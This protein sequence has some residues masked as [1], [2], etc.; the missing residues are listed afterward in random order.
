MDFNQSSKYRYKLFQCFI[1]TTIALF[2][3]EK[4]S[5]AQS[6][7]PVWQP[8]YT[9]NS[10]PQ[11]QPQQAPNDPELNRN[12]TAEELEQTIRALELIEVLGFT[13]LNVNEVSSI[14]QELQQLSTEQSPPYK[15]SPQQ[16]Q[17]LINLFATLS[18]SELTA[19][20]QILITQNSQASIA[21]TPEEIQNL[22]EVLSS[23]PTENLSNL[24]QEQ[25]AVIQDFFSKIPAN[26]TV[27]LSPEQ[28]EALGSAIEFV[29][30]TPEA[31]STATGELP[32]F[33]RSEQVTLT[34]LEL[35]QTI[36]GLQAIQQ[37]NLRPNQE[38]EITQLLN[39]LENQQETQ[40]DVT[41]SAAQ[42]Q[43]L[44]NLIG[45]LTPN[46]TA[47]IEILLLSDR[48]PETLDLTQQEIDDLLTFFQELPTE[49]FTA[50]QRQ[51][52]TELINFL[53][54]IREQEATEIRLS[55]AQTQAFLQGIQILL[56][57]QGAI[58]SATVP[59]EQLQN[60]ITYIET[61]QKEISLSSSQAQNIAELRQK[62]ANLEPNANNQ[63]VI[64]PEQNQQLRTFINS[65]NRRQ[66]Q[67][68]QR[69]LIVQAGGSVSSPSISVLNPIG[70]GNSWGNIGV[71]LSY[72]ER[73]RFGD[74]EDGSLSFSMG[75]GDPQRSVG[76]DTTVTILSL[77]DDNQSAAFSTGSMSF[78]LSRN[79]SNNTAV[80][81]G[82]EN[83]IRWPEGSGDSGTSTYL[84]GSKLFQLR[85][86]P[87]SPFGIAYLTAG[88]GNGRFRPPEDFDFEDDGF[89]FNPF[90][91]LAV[92]VL[93]RVNAMTE[94]TGQDISVGLSIVPFREIPLVITLAGIDL[95]GN[96]EEAFGREGKA[97]FTGAVSYGFFF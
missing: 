52:R 46:E 64:P 26:E 36:R 29:F 2:I 53:S 93:P 1:L 9:E 47:A 5:I 24:Q 25:L 11:F 28:T 7:S 69:E 90:A 65:L 48:A 8:A 92:Q 56:F 95:Q 71:G 30:F 15:L 21:L 66:R 12:L 35:E 73:T 91:S 57:D 18:E 3:S 33:E 68:I 62:L 49:N 61:A 34:P 44:R 42:T 78:K 19:I 70:Y 59:L 6:Q 55:S 76:F 86:E 79:L 43:Q 41:L 32:E 84:V 80:S 13:S 17:Q 77:T 63:F 85:D 96:A 4:S 51:Q 60:I 45:S 81:L 38:E 67:D 74:S 50:T 40:T 22:R 20:N 97:R 10:P 54:Q 37:G 75:F 31:Q 27:S 88:V 39:Q 83:L 23:I 82:V 89:Q 87:F 72:Q 14:R 94:W 16:N 58:A